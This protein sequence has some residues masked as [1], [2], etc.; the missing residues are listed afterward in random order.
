MNSPTLAVRVAGDGD[1][2]CLRDAQIAVVVEFH[3]GR[4]DEGMAVRMEDRSLIGDPYDMAQPIRVDL[5]GRA[6]SIAW[7]EWPIRDGLPIGEKAFPKDR[8]VEWKFP[9]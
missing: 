8:R 7:K 6:G 5:T 1:P 4:G 2:R 3:A 9:R